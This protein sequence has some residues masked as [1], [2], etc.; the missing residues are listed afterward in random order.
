[1]QKKYVCCKKRNVERP[2]KDS[3]FPKKCSP[4]EQHLA[5]RGR[6]SPTHLARESEN[7]RPAIARDSGSEAT[8]DFQHQRRKYDE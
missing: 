5:A 8:L 2:V 6:F 4:A 1:M 3:Q 7:I